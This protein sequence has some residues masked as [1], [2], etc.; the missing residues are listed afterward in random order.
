MLMTSQPV[1]RVEIPK[2]MILQTVAEGQ[3]LGIPAGRK[4]KEGDI[5]PSTYYYWLKSKD[6]KKAGDGWL[7]ADIRE[8]QESNYWAYGAFRMTEALKHSGKCESINHKRI[9]RV[10]REHKP[11]AKARR[12]RFPKDY[13]K[14][15]KSNGPKGQLPGQ[16]LHGELLRPPEV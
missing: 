8:L 15:M 14:A 6:A 1:R 2:K 12:R 5:V 13:Y 4:L 10:M 9:G 3:H 16:R 7:A 11:N